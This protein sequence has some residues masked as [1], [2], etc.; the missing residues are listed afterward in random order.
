M[1]KP[2][3]GVIVA[4]S[5]LAAGLAAAARQ[6]SGLA[7]DDLVALSN[8]GEG[9]QG[10]ASAV[11]GALGDGPAIIFTDLGSG[12]CNFAAR[13]VAGDRHETGVVCGV[14]LPILIDF[15]FHREMPVAELVDRLVD[16]GRTGI[17]GTCVV[18]AAH[19]D[20]PAPR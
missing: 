8:E 19:A 13:K 9:P 5:T 7:E 4:H 11:Q 18:E 3:K 16:K 14:N 6:I 1:S 2:V 17:S 10:I 12:S 15:A 20:R